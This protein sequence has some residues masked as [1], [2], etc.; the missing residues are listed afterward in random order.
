VLTS[1]NCDDLHRILDPLLVVLLDKSTIRLNN[2]YQ[3]EYDCRR[4]LYVFRILES[5]I[6]CDFRSFM[7]N[8][9]ERPITKDLAAL[10]DKHVLVLD[11]SCAG[12]FAWPKPH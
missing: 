9:V 10:N 11:G 5:I 4:V 12:L 1:V 2:V 8:V 7:L 3:T 6:E